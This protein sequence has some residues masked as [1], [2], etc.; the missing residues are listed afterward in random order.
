MC[1]WI[2]VIQTQ[3]RLQRTSL[4]HL[5]FLPFRLVSQRAGDWFAFC[6]RICK[7]NERATA[8]LAKRNAITWPTDES[9]SAMK[10]TFGISVPCVDVCDFRVMEWE[11]RTTYSRHSWLP[12]VPLVLN[13]EIWCNNKA[14]FPSSVPFSLITT[15]KWCGCLSFRANCFALTNCVGKVEKMSLFLRAKCLPTGT[16]VSVSK[17][18]ENT[19]RTK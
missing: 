16:S 19:C 4:V 9:L 11:M 2:A 8:Q 18:L 10:V 13:I 14:L 5:P 3:F 12:F 17:Q 6:T 7:L 1:N 15:W